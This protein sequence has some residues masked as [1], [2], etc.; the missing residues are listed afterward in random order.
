MTKYLA[1]EEILRLHY[2]VITDF[3][4]SHGVRDERRLESVEAAPKQEVFGA[5]QYESVFE[6][7]AVYLIILL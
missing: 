5:E 4:G 3:G 2:Q 6:K 1:L 7:A